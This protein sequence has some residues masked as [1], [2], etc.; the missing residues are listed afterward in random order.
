[1]SGN[2]GFKGFGTDTVQFLEDLED[3]NNRAW[4]Q[5]N[6][7][8]YESD[9]LEPA[10]AFISA[11]GPL[12]ARV[13]DRFTAIP[14]RMG[15]SLMRVYRDTRFSRDKTPYKT[16]IGIQFRHEQGKDVHAPGY[17]LH[18]ETTG[19]FLG[20]GMWRPEPVALKAIRERIAE[21]P[22]AWRKVAQSR[23]F[24]RDYTLGGNTLKRPPRGFAPDLPYLE[25]IKRKD[26][27]GVSDFSIERAASADFPEEVVQRFARATPLM[28]FLCTAVGVQF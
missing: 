23:R 9:V 4:F 10:L 11:T 7:H 14:K 15:G 21:R 13:S 26:F 6:K 20:A 2:A 19:C 18:M 22:D 1:M 12:L 3:N 27:I 28:K 25:D 8:R 24:K 16:N 17:Y 5:E